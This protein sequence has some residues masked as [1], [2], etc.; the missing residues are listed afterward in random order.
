MI[1]AIDAYLKH[2]L[3]EYYTSWGCGSKYY[4]VNRRGQKQKLESRQVKWNRTFWYLC[5]KN[6]YRNW[7]HCRSLPT[8]W[9]RVFHEK[10][11]CSYLLLL[12]CLS[13]CDNIE[14]YPNLKQLKSAFLIFH[15][16][17]SSFEIIAFSNQCSPFLEEEDA[18]LLSP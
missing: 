15:P 5:W 2:F 12:Q 14:P 17:K 11:W 9:L 6:M 16:W 1:T 8:L 3:G 4:R 10:T 13:D 18:K 7:N